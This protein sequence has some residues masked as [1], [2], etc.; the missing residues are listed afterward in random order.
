[1]MTDQGWPDNREGVCVCVCVCVC[2]MYTGEGYKDEQN[3]K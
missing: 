3:K 2:V 1:M